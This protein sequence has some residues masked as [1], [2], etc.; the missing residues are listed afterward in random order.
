MERSFGLLKPDCLK[1]GITKE[2]LILIES[3]GLKIVAMKTI[4]LTKENVDTIWPSCR[5]MEFYDSMVEFSITGDCLVFI[6]EG[7]NAI[8][9]LTTLVGHYEPTKAK[10]GTI[11]RLFGTSA[12]ENVIHS[13]SD[14]DMYE[15]EKSLFFDQE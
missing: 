2:V 9:R 10:K 4:R 14:V 6:V 12:M 7:D 13:A 15:K 1:R 11:R 3:S 8:G 5:S